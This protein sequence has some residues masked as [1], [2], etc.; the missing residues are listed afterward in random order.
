MIAVAGVLNRPTGLR[1]SSSWG[2]E[3]R[4][5]QASLA[6]AAEDVPAGLGSQKGDSA[7]DSVRVAS[8]TA[9]V[10][11]LVPSPTDPSPVTPLEQLVAL[12]DAEL[13]LLAHAIG[14][15][16]AAELVERVRDLRARQAELL[17]HV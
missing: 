7:T 8:D 3:I 1:L 10:L 4:A 15:H 16:L 6:G 13:R 17:P 12:Q 11:Q 5:G 2:T 9:V 14:D